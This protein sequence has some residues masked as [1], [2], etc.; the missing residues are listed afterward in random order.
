ME[1]Q[2]P[3][4]AAKNKGNEAFKRKHFEEAL[5][6]YDEAITLNQIQPL[7]YNNKAATFIEM[8]DYQS[9]MQEILKAEQVM[10]EPDNKEKIQDYFVKR[11]K[12]LARKASIYAKQ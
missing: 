10:S 6:H 9:A 1:V 7:Y 11:A 2:Q 8:K 12:V 3:A 4:E 5:K